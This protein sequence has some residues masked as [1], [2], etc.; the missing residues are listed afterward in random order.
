MPKG[1]Q[2]WTLA[3]R[4]LLLFG[5]VILVWTA[6]VAIRFLPMPVRMPALLAIFVAL[7]ARSVYLQIWL[8][9]A[10]RNRNA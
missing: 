2:G 3:W 5:G 9:S 10:K 4:V 1:P 8:R 6:V 7:V